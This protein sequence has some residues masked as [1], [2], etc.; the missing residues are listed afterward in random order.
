MSSIIP[1]ADFGRIYRIRA[2]HLGE[3]GVDVTGMN[4]AIEYA[5]RGEPDAVRVAAAEDR[6]SR[7]VAFT[8]PA[9]TSLVGWV[10]IPLELAPLAESTD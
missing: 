9:M 10:T 3:R 5:E 1:A 7:F 8:D 4:S 2:G 6:Q